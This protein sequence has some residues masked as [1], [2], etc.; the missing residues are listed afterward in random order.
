LPLSFNID[1]EILARGIRKEKEI[2]GIKIGKEELKLSLFADNSILYT[3][4][5]KHYT[6]ILLGLMS[7]HSKVAGYKNQHTKISRVPIH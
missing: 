2:L 4:N 1:L 3:E 5:P 7:K 6:K